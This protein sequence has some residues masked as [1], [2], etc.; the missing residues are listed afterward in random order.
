MRRFPGV[1][2]Q[3]EDFAQD[4]ARRLLERY[5]DRLCTFNDD[6]QGTG[7]VTLAGLLAA[8]RCHGRAARD[9]RIVIL[10][11]GSA[12]TGIAGQSVAAIVR[13]GRTVD[14]AKAAIWRGRRP[15]PRCMWR[16]WTEPARQIAPRRWRARSPITWR[17]R[18]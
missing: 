12:A 11:A 4:N 18:A 2:L 8:T 17:P 5:R 6:I 3:W 14:E 7:A 1:L 15:L 9:Q 13:E 10:G 16:T